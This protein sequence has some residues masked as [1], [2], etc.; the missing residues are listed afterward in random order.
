MENTLRLKI[1]SIDSSTRVQNTVKS[2]VGKWKEKA[3][4]RMEGV[5]E[6]VG[7]TLERDLEGEWRP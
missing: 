4:K 7:V 3:G 2:N 1:Y 5:S 6:L